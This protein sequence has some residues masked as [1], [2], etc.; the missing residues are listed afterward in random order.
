VAGVPVAGAAGNPALTSGDRA[1]LTAALVAEA[2]AVTTYAHILTTAPFFQRLFPQD[3]AYLKAAHQQEMAHYVL[4]HGLAGT[5]TPYT[6]FF[7]PKGMF[8]DAR[9]TVNT[10]VALEEA[11]IA[12]YLVGVRAF[13]SSDLRVAA[14]RIMGVE[15]DHRTMARVLAPGLDPADGGPLRT[16]SGI[17]GVAE[18]VD[19]ASN[20]GFERTLGWTGIEQVLAAL[21]PF[22]DRKAAAG[23]RFDNSR[24]YA[25]TPFTPKLTTPLGAF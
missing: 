22:V 11:F 15:S 3:Q 17:K 25:F 8:A 18:A 12:A 13:S 24:V 23:A 21:Q 7:Y 4:L 16:V 20:N 9:T 2:L 6:S 10:L 5:A 1:I 19:P 14:A